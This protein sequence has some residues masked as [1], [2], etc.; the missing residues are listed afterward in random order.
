M[1]S[2]IHRGIKT[3]S[4]KSKLL[5]VELHLHETTHLTI[6]FLSIIYVT[7]ATGA[8]PI[9]PLPTLSALITSLFTSLKTG[10]CHSFNHKMNRAV[11]TPTVNRCFSTNAF[12][13]CTESVLSPI[14]CTF[15]GAKTSFSEPRFNHR[16]CSVKNIVTYRLSHLETDKPL[17][18]IQTTLPTISSTRF[19][20]LGNPKRPPY[21]QQD[22]RRSQLECPSRLGQT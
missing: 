7:R 3:I 22:T 2:I 15:P 14:I 21:L 9:I 6:P 20:K 13:F 5:N 19:R 10:Y 11:T 18:C 1:S 17:E 4:I 8:S 16:A 12:C